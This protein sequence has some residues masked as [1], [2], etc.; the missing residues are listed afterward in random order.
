M[1]AITQGATAPQIFNFNTTTV[2]AIDRE[3]QIWFVASDIAKALEYKDARQMTRW[4]EADESTLHNV[5]TS[6]KNRYGAISRTVEVAI[7]NESG[8]YA[9]VLRSRK[10][11][12]RAF[13]KWVTAEVLPAIRKTGSYTLTINAEQQRTIQEA[14]NAYVYKTGK[15]HQHVYSGLKTRFKVA[16][17]DQLPV[18]RF[19]DAIKWLEGEHI[20]ASGYRSQG[21][22]EAYFRDADLNAVEY[23]F[24]SLSNVVEKRGV[25]PRSKIKPPVFTRTSHFD[26]VRT[27]QVAQ[28][29]A[30]ELKVWGMNSLPLEVAREFCAGMD[31][32]YDLLVT[33]WTEVNE[34][35]SAFNRGMHFLNRWNGKLIH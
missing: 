2:R 6:S 13:R 16:K 32:I 15:T 3:G 28:K 24:E 9:A 22:L 10:P 1:T 26:S 20:P 5:Q 14:V 12:A 25:L 27:V 23:L 11:A 19:D 8:M 29:V 30:M 34:A 31:E 21:E 33:G 7:V 17:Y 18:T 4:L 35:L